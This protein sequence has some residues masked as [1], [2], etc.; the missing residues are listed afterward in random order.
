[1]ALRPFHYA[2]FEKTRKRLLKELHRILTDNDKQ[3][4]LSFKSGEP[5]WNLSDIEQLKNLP[6]VQWKLIHIRKLK[7][8]NPKKH[9]ALFKKLRD[10]LG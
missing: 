6:A 4:L 8:D 3:L 1:M 2:D 5:D 7:K 10:V 9:A